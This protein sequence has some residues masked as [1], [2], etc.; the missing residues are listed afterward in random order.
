MRCSNPDCRAP[1][2]GPSSDDPSGVTNTGVA[3]HICA[4]APGGA[5]YDSGMTPE[6]RS[7]IRN[8]ILL[9]QTDAKL[10]DDD[11]L[12]FTTGLLREW[13]AT[14]EQIA[15]LEARGY[16]IT[17]ARP[18]ADLESKAPKLIAEMRRDLEGQPLVRQFVL[19]PNSRVSYNASYPQFSYHEDM[20]PY[21]R[22]MMTIMVHAGAIYDTK[23]NSV[24]RYNFTEEFVRFL[25]GDR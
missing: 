2:S 9:C 22:P 21:L 19:L 23:F 18:F 5:R 1:T 20:H 17:K 16:A 13:K 11:E 6:Q 12:A 8:G 25:I 7:D 15:A 10:I 3:S 4:A 14:A 24:P